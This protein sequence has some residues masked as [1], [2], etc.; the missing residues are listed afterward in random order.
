[1]S[2]LADPYIL[3]CILGILATVTGWLLKTIVWPGIIARLKTE[4]RGE[5]EN[6]AG[7]ISDFG[8]RLSNAE[9]RYDG[10]LND[11]RGRLSRLEERN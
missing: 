9:E 6:D 10:Q 2:F 7:V 11:V 5:L 4:L 8:R 3:L 1:M